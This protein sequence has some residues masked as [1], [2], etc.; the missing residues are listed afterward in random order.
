MYIQLPIISHSCRAEVRLPF[1]N[2]SK[3]QP[4]DKDTASQ[5]KLQIP[6][7]DQEN[8]LRETFETFEKT[9]LSWAA[10]AGSFALAWQLQ[11]G[12]MDSLLKGPKWNLPDI[13][14]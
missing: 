14:K 9:S 11:F 5:W 7:G 2:I 8:K 10:V 12:Q 4:T 13:R 1:V 3:E 6:K